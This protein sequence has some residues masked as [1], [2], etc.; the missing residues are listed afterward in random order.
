MEYDYGD[1]GQSRE[2]R[3]IYIYDV[4]PVDS[5]LLRFYLSRDSKPLICIYLHLFWGDRVL[6]FT[7]HVRPRKVR[8][9]N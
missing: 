1:Q 6:F 3:R 8:N 7:E 5:G 2:S 4:S 9:I